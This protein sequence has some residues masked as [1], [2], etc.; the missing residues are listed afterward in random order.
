MFSDQN[1]FP[2]DQNIGKWTIYLERAWFFF[3][4]GVF[5]ENEACFVTFSFRKSFVKVLNLS[6]LFCGHPVS[7]EI[8]QNFD[9]N[10]HWFIKL[11]MAFVAIRLV[12][13]R[14]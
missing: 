14:P 6:S 10:V 12:Q 8:D 11:Q 3:S 9:Q 5:D 2:K 4:G 13:T 7:F 1:N